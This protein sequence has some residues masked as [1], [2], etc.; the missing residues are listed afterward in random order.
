[1]GNFQPH[2]HHV[3]SIMIGIL[4]RQKFKVQVE[5]ERGAILKQDHL[6]LFSHMCAGISNVLT[7]VAL[8][9]TSAT[10]T[11]RIIK[12]FEYRT[13]KSLVLHGVN[14]ESTTAG[15]LK[16]IARQG[17]LI[18]L[19]RISRIMYGVWL[20]CSCPDSTGM[21]TLSKCCIRSVLHEVVSCSHLTAD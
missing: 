2:Q 13:E 19:S 20:E 9:T 4:T 12:S 11:L 21:E 8:P 18:L 1:M 14:L 5:A 6:Q 15:E 7:N 16:D 10:L 3:C 17:I